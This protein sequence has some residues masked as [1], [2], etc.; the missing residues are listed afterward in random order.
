MEDLKYK[1]FFPLHQ[2]LTIW[3]SQIE[4]RISIPSFLK[5]RRCRKQVE[6]PLL[7]SQ[8]PQNQTPPGKT[9]VRTRQGVPKMVWH[10]TFYYL[11]DG[12]RDV[13]QIKDYPGM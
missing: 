13:A 11:C 7:T 1:I 9:G 5:F 10:D 6:V 3:L 4:P 12:S 2:Y 8:T